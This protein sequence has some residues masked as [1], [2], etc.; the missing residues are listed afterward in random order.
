MFFHAGIL[1][2]IVIK[3]AKEEPFNMQNWKEKIA[4]LTECPRCSRKLGADDRR[5]FSSYDHEPICMDCKK[6]EEARPDYET[7]SREMIGSCMADAELQQGDAE[8]FCYNHFYP[9]KC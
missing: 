5:I 6:A 4:C 7:V 9:Y 8:A 2:L 1:G 3:T